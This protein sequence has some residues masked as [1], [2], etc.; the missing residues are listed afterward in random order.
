MSGKN[1]HPPAAPA[2]IVMP[3]FPPGQIDAHQCGYPILERSLLAA[4]RPVR[5][6]PLLTW[7]YSRSFDAI[8]QLEGLSVTGR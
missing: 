5:Q 8:S 1:T 3:F 6:V 4:M 2:A 7:R